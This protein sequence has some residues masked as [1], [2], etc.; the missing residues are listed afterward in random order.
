MQV[1][2]CVFSVGPFD[3]N[4]AKG[5][6]DTASA[7]SEALAADGLWSSASLHNGKGAKHDLTCLDKCTRSPPVELARSHT[8]EYVARQPCSLARSA[9]DATIATTL[10]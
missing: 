5:N 3:C 7:R 6:A 9:T 4:T 8:S 1:F 10:N 2:G